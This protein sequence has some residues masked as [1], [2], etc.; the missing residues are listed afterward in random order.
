MLA[1][2]VEILFVDRL[3]FLRD[4]QREVEHRLLSRRDV[5]LAVVGRD[6]VCDQRVLGADAQDG[7]VGDDAVLAFVGRRGGDHDHLALGLGEPALL[8]HQ[9]VVIGEEGAELVGPVRQRDEDIGHE[10]RLLLHALDALADVVR[11]LGEIG[12]G[13]A[14]DGLVGHGDRLLWMARVC[15][16]SA[17]RRLT[18]IKQICGLNAN[19][20]GQNRCVAARLAAWS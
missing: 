14:A 1:Q 3:G 2:V 10:A 20:R 9:R 19:A 6:L 16:A 13:K 7:A 8:V 18:S 4:Q 17:A 12:N 15:A 11:Q 5:G